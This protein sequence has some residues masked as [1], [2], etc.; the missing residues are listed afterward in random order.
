LFDFLYAK[1]LS[2]KQ[3]N[4]EPSE[5]PGRGGHF[6]VRLHPELDQEA[7]IEKAVRAVTGRLISATA[8]S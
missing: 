3:N 2:A 4:L 8:G 1:A 6:P 5:Q 7:V